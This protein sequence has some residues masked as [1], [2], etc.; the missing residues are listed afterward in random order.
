[1]ALTCFIL[2]PQLLKLNKL[3][4]RKIMK[5]YQ[6]IIF[7]FA[8]GFLFQSCE[9][10][11]ME[12]PPANTKNAVFEQIW[13]F[14]D[15]KYSFFDYKK[16]DWNAVKA[17][18]KPKVNENMTDEQ[19]LKVCDEMLDKLKDGH[20]NIK[21]QFDRTRNWSFVYDSPQN[22]NNTILE[23]NYF[24]DQ[25]QYIGPFTFKDFN[26]VAY[27]YYESFSD[28]ISA[29][30]LD[31]I[32]EKAQSKKGI[33]IDIR[34]NGGGSKSNVDLIAERFCE[35]KTKLG[36]SWTKNGKAHDAFYKEDSY[37][38]PSSNVKKFLNKPI[39][40]LTNRSSYSASSFFTFTMKALPNVT[41][42]GDITGGGGGI[43]AYTELSNG[44]VLRVSSTQ[45]IDNKGFNIENGIPPNTK[46]DMS[47]ADE[48]LGKDT[49]LDTAL[50]F[51]RK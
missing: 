33:I 43:P 17:E 34:D 18:F 11:L 10:L 12:E 20:V 44:W 9:I 22:Y 31:Y 7:I 14:A 3:L 4:E 8:L 24:K 28:G 48:N 25:E 1:M 6:H 30:D 36:Q 40:I 38:T 2:Q 26:D 15:E 29:K 41:Q 16:V 37:L 27:V 49:I 5:K 50:A 51:L 21:T 42:I 19:F 46:I 47:K 13:K 23:R 45:T 32:I 35:S 39:V